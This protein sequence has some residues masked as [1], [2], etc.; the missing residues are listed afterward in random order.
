MVLLPKSG[1]FTIAAL[2]ACPWFLFAAFGCGAGA[3]T[4]SSH[5]GETGAAGQPPASGGLAASGGQ[6][7]SGGQ[8]AMGGQRATGG[9]S[10]TV[11]GLVITSR[12]AGVVRSAA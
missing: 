8:T 4:V 3:G 7:T 12:G 6:V 5:G 2:T 10:G 1:R 9:S 11:H